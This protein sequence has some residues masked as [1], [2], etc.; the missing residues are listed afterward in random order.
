MMFS[1]LFY[2]LLMPKWSR[3][4]LPYWSRF[5]AGWDG[6][7]NFGRS[8]AEKVTLGSIGY[9]SLDQSPG[10]GAFAC[11][12]SV[13]SLQ[14]FKLLAVSNRLKVLQHQEKIHKMDNLIILKPTEVQ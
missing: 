9:F 6:I 7:F 10:P 14:F 13:C 1:N 8:T 2:A 3:S 4:L 12:A 5:V 11:S